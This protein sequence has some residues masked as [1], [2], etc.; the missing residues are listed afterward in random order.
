MALPILDGNQSATTLSTIITG[1]AH[2]PAHTVVSLGSQAISDITSGVS[3]SVVSI[4]N[5]PSTQTIAGTV[6]IG[7]FPTS[8]QYIE[9]KILND[10]TDTYY[11]STNPFPISGTVTDRKSTRLNSS[12]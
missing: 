1:G 9:A 10:D 7:A 6:T 8:D 2:I 11:N 3:G 12:H 5:F 4:S